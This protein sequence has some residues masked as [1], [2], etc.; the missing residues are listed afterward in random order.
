MEKKEAELVSQAK[1]GD[2]EAFEILL[3][4]YEARTYSS[5]YRILGNRSDASDVLQEASIRA[6]QALPK[7]SGR[8]SFGT[9]FY[10]IAIILC[11]LKL[12]KQKKA[13]FSRE[14]MTTVRKDDGKEQP[15]SYTHLRAHET[16]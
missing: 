14:A 12:R 13:P 1:R 2:R 16:R 4:K 5:A 3:K 11:L 7:F 15:V 8:S 9:W 10:R 6:F